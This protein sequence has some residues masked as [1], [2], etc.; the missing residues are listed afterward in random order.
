MGRAANPNFWP[1]ARQGP[2]LK[3]LSAAEEAQ[4]EP[5]ERI[6]RVWPMIVR[7]CSQ[8]TE[9]MRP[10]GVEVPTD[11]LIQEFVLHVLERDHKW[12]PARGKYTTFVGRLWR[13]VRQRQIETHGVV[14]GPHNA[15]SIM[16]RFQARHEAGQ[17]SKAECKTLHS[18]EILHRLDVPLPEVL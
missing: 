3:G 7:L 12:N 15:W 2:T 14:T 10:R 8:H 1:Y 11:D 9:V 5:H 4:L 6:R 17:L 13:N 16:K 18:L